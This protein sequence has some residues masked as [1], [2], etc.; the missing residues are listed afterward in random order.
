MKSETFITASS[1]FHLWWLGVVAVAVFVRVVY[2]WSLGNQAPT[3]ADEHVHDEIAWKLVQTGCYESSAYRA[4]PFVPGC[5]AAV[6]AVFGHDYRAARICQGITG[7]VLLVLS[8]V[9]IGSILFNRT[10]GLL[11]GI[12]VAL[13]PQLI[14]LSGLFYAEHMFAVLLSMMVFCL[15]RW[16]QVQQNAWLVVGGVL[17]GLSALCRPVALGVAP[18]VLAY[19]GWKATGARRRL[20]VLFFLLAAGAVVLPWTVRNAM[21]FRHFVLIS[22]GSGLHLWRGNNEV[23]QGDADDRHL[24][25]F[26]D[27]WKE[28]VACL[29][30]VEREKVIKCVEKLQAEVGQ[31][32]EVEGDHRFA[33]EGRRWL[34]AHPQEFLKQSYRRLITLY[35]AFSRTLSKNETTNARNRL[36]AAASFYPVLG[37]G[38]IGVVLAWRRTRASWVV[39][40]VI[41][42]LTLVYLPM[43]ACTRF[44]MPLDSLWILLA[45][46]SVVEM[47]RWVGGVFDLGKPSH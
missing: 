17:L 13:Y 9:G 29:G 34:I 38:L 16:Q 27:L 35:S 46:A 18:F 20:K 43:T 45:S 23:S 31:L 41:V 15:V 28:R 47:L 30:T 8:I 42:G 33:A 36:I 6:Y 25:P 26:G 39:H 11:A 7:G 24:I 2:A 12:G 5:M 3:W 10:T 21:V 22:T 32:D 40:G 19:V 44:R 4:T 14:Y 37:F 1:R